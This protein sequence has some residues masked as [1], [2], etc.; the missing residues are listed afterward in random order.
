MTG[1]DVDVLILGAGSAGYACALRAA[2][3]GLSVTLVEKDRL[4]GTCLHRGCIPTKALL[5]SAEV[6]DAARE[7]SRFGVLAALEGIDMAGVQAYSDGVV[8]RLFTG[9]TGLVRSRGV[10]V[11]EGAGRVT[12]PREVTVDGVVHTGRALVLA[13]GSAPSVLPGIEVDGARVLTSDDALRLD[14]VPASALVLGGGV[15]G[16]E[17]AS[18]WRSFGTEVTILE[19]ADR[20]L[21]SEDPD[22]VAVLARAFRRRGI[23]A[24]TGEVF[25]SV[26][27]TDEGVAVTLEGGEVLEAEVLLVAVGRRPVTAG[28][29]LEDVG[30]ATERGYVLTDE[31]CRTSVEGIY[32]VGDIAPGL[33][34]AHRGFAQGV[35][36]A[37]DVA[38]LSPAPVDETLVPRVTYS[39]PEVASVGLGEADARA[40]FGDDVVTLTYDL[41][42]NGRSQILRTQGHVKL[43]RRADGP[44]VG[45]H[46]VGERVGELIGEAQLVVGW[47]AHPEDVAPLVHAHPTQ[48]EALGEAHLAL[49]GKALH[50]HG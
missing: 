7:A 4:G 9:L 32:A 27:T 44:V 43:V 2:Q 47:E 12:G 3:L 23:T 11:V 20:L 17:L 34:L 42:G 26:K 50:A 1:T 18:A 41:A 19:A 15:I 25:Q 37:E 16:C 48:S 40:R 10:T 28:L 8:G 49:A 29:G 24:R 6:A 30:V 36:V 45:I 13:T 22:S 39:S 31:R 38:G 35:F 33:Q 21:P 5:H 14:H 46:L